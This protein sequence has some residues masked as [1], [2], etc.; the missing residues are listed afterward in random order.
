MDAKSINKG[1]V[2]SDLTVIELARVVEIGHKHVMHVYLCECTCGERL[3]VN[4]GELVSGHIKSCGCVSKPRFQALQYDL[5]DC[6]FGKLHVIDQ[7]DTFWS[8]SGKSRMVRWNCE[9]E[10]GK[11]V[12]VNSRA[13][14]TGATQSCGCYQKQRVSEALTDDLTNKRFGLLYVLERTG[15]Y[16]RKNSSSGMAVMWKC[17]CDCGNEIVTFGWSLKCGDN[18]SC[19]C[20]KRSEAERTVEEI[21]SDN[22]Y[23]KDVTFFTEISF[24]DLIGFEGHRLR[25]DF[26]IKT[27]DKYVFIECQG[28]QHY[29]SVDF[30]G[31]N[32]A[33]V[34]RQEN[35]KLKRKWV[36]EHNYR[37]IE[38]PY[39][40]RGRDDFLKVL[41]K[42]HIIELAN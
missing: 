29:K 10:C 22:G 24:P 40:I 27:N 8:D 41:A 28:E 35:D 26:A 15:S 7:A 39:T 31:G 33:F 5:T 6:Y 18:V 13:L 21:L 34:H 32:K 14:R 9:C 36:S 20:A 2:F 19:G 38:I 23:V 25:F 3:E 4:Q 42:E 11:K 16:R 30:F 1:D 17:K 37:L 12:V